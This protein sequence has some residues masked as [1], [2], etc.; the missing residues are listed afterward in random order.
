MNGVL[1]DRPESLGETKGMS[2]KKKKKK[3]VGLT[4]PAQSAPVFY[5]AGIRHASN[6]VLRLALGTNG[7]EDNGKDARFGRAVTSGPRVLTA[8]DD[9]DERGGGQARAMPD[10]R[11]RPAVSGPAFTLSLRCTLRCLAR[12]S[13][14]EKRLSQ[15]WQRYGL[16]PE[17]ERL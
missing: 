4:A 2:Q 14:R 8:G 17:W 6:G 11:D 15:I 9:G 16:M 10:V 3:F 7:N 5:P 1:L 12:W 13:D